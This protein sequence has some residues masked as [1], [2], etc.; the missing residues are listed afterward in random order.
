MQKLNTGEYMVNYTIER[1]NVSIELLCTVNVSGYCREETRYSPAEYPESE[2]Q[3]CIVKSIYDE[4]DKAI[5]EACG[6]KVGS[7]ALN[8]LQI[9]QNEIECGALELAIDSYEQALELHIEEQNNYWRD[10][11]F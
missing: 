9:E 7:K 8:L 2:I 3:S 4:N 5:N 1:E 6:Y 11:R 10:N